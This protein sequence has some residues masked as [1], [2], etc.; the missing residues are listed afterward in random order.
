M[1]AYFA[2]TTS[3][4][5]AVLLDYNLSEDEL[6]ELITF[7]DCECV[8]YS[9]TYEDIA[10]ALM[11][12]TGIPFYETET[13]FKGI[14]LESEQVDIKAFESITV[15]E[16]DI[17]EI[18]F[19]SG[20]SGK[21][22]GV[23]LSNAN[24]I[25]NAE[26]ALKILMPTA[27]SLQILP[28]YHTYGL[29]NLIAHFFVGGSCFIEDSLRNIVGDVGK[30]EFDTI[31]AVPAMLPIL[32]DA[33][34]NNGKLNKVKVPCGGAPEDK[35]M[36]AKLAEIGVDAYNCYGMTECSPCIAIGNDHNGIN[37]TS[38]HIIDV[39]TVMIDS[40]DENGVGEILVSGANVMIGYYKMQV[41]TE[42]VLRDGVLRTGDLGKIDEN[43][44]LTVTGRKK[45]IIALPNG[46]KVSPE[47][48][49]QKV[50][51]LGG[52][53]ECVLAL[54]NDIL[55]LSIWA[56]DGDKDSIQKEIVEL[57]RNIPA[58][59]RI[60]KI[61]FSETSFAVNSIGKTIRKGIEKS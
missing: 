51:Q 33:Y 22:K 4:N 21:Y 44:R 50:R 32:Y 41:E 15:S 24:V 27:M 25:S 37:D 54:Q 58:S 38:M 11:E 52:V 18:A 40:P 17:A 6:S 2:I 39:N 1:L 28:L 23:M 34:K 12:K 35:A 8:F 60:A 30:Y 49:E 9:A 26:S 5:A 10:S 55:V 43:G 14:C 29:L 56:P 31:S 57:N 61:V 48:V 19:T 47:A 3:G 16:N 53:S 59:K 46:E 13:F 42:K 36:L 45:N 20:T 7:S